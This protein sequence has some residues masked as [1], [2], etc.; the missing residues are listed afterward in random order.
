MTTKYNT[1]GDIA[2]VTIAAAYTSDPIV[3]PVDSGVLHVFIANTDLVG[4]LA[5]KGGNIDDVTKAIT[6]AFEDL[7]TGALATSVTISS[8]VNVNKLIRFEKLPGK[9]WIV[10]TYTSGSGSLSAKFAQKR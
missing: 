3:L 5:I 7:E 9:L 8:G 2:A 4:S 6:L 10:I 1:G